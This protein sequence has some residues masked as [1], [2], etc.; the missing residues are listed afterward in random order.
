MV[1]WCVCLVIK[2]KSITMQGNMN[3]KITS[4]SAPNVHLDTITDSDTI[5]NNA[6]RYKGKKKQYLPLNSRHVIN[7]EGTVGI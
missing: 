1:N 6:K 3:I 5:K 7:T 4:H 2:K